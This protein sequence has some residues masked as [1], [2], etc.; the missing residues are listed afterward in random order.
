MQNNKHIYLK[1]S[2]DNLDIKNSI[3]IFL[4]NQGFIHLNLLNKDDL[5]F[6]LNYT[7]LNILSISTVLFKNKNIIESFDLFFKI[8][9][10]KEY[11]NL[12]LKVVNKIFI[13]QEN[14]NILK[15]LKHYNSDV[16]KYFNTI[17]LSLDSVSN[18]FTHILGLFKDRERSPFID[19]LSISNYYDNNILDGQF[20]PPDRCRW[21]SSF[22]Q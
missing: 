1:S 5:N 21:R 19:Y 3:I 10:E 11:D 14:L 8:Y 17:T 7:Y 13:F 22:Y 12:K 2:I 4:R 6:V 15:S 9:S 18:G 16:Y 20:L